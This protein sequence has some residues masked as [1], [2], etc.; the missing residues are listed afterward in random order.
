MLHQNYSDNSVMPLLMGFTPKTPIMEG[1]INE[2]FTY[3]DNAQITEYDMVTIGT[4][5]LKV[6]GNTSKGPGKGYTLDKKNV[7]DDSKTK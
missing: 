1:S 7:I 6:V 5:C 3:D 2:N 4:K